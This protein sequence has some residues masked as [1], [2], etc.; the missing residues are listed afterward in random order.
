MPLVQ[1][2]Q[3][4]YPYKDVAGNLHIRYTTHMPL[5]GIENTLSTSTSHKTYSLYEAL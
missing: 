1:W 3:M 5:K 4:D 2:G